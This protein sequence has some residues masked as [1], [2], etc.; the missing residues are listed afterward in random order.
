M[1]IP[2]AG[3]PPGGHAEGGPRSTGGELGIG[4]SA[5]LLPPGGSYVVDGPQD[6]A[7]GSGGIDGA[8]MEGSPIDGAGDGIG[9]AVVGMGSGEGTG[10][11]VGTKERAANLEAARFGGSDLVSGGGGWMWGAGAGL[12]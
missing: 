3:S 2:A 6:A 12:Q 4:A 7:A 1:D 5:P 11:V 8:R 10:S 9:D